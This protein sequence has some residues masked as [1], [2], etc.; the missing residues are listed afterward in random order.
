M[1]IPFGGAKGG[2]CVDPKD[3]SE[4]ELEIL[5]RKLVQVG[6]WAGGWVPTV[7]KVGGAGA[8]AVQMCS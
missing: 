8:L 4:R 3:L 5:T 1:D 2:I 6:G 7:S